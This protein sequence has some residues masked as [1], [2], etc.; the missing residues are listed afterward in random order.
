M[1]TSYDEIFYSHLHDDSELLYRGEQANGN[2]IH[3]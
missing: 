3:S 2:D 1:L